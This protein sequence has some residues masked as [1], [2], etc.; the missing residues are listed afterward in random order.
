MCS[1]DLAYVL[2]AHQRR[3]IGANLLEHL[4]ART[5]P[6]V[7]IGTWAAAT[8]AIRFY[9]KYGFALVAADLKE[10]LLR[11][12]W[13]VPERQIATSVVLADARGQRHFSGLR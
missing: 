13:T 6:P 7:L 1:S 8:W 5:E 11:Q 10:R 3:G 12:Y 9:E 4:L 2:S